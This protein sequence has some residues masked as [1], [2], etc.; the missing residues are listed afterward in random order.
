MTEEAPARTRSLGERLPDVLY[1][2][3][4]LL[5]LSPLLADLFGHRFTDA[6]ARLGHGL[7]LGLSGTSS[8]LS[9]LLSSS[10]GEIRGWLVVAGTIATAATLTAWARALD[11]EPGTAPTARQRRAA[12]PWQLAV[13]V[14]AL[15]AVLLA[16]L[17]AAALEPRAL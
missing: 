9:G 5:G 7:Y 13:G 11:P 15:L 3:V 2:L 12:L 17:L 1:T 8:W 10:G 6:G 4:V 14:P 16:V